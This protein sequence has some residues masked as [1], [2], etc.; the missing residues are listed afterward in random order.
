MIDIQLLMTIIKKGPEL[1]GL[2]FLIINFL[3]DGDFIV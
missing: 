3:G 2:F 1:Q